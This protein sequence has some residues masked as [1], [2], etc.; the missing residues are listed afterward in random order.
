MT[1]PT[2]STRLG[3]PERTPTSRTV[4]SRSGEPLR[5]GSEAWLHAVGRAGRPLARAMPWL[6]LT[7]LNAAILAHLATNQPTASTTRPEPA[8]PDADEP[9]PAI[10]L[11]PDPFTRRRG[12]WR[13][14]VRRRSARIFGV[15]GQ[16]PRPVAV[17]LESSGRD[18]WTNG[19]QEE[20]CQ[21]T[22]DIC[23]D[24]SVPTEGSARSAYARTVEVRVKKLFRKDDTRRDSALALLKGEGDDPPTRSAVQEALGHLHDGWSGLRRSQR[25]RRNRAIGLALMFAVL[26]VGGAW[27][28]QGDVGGLTLSSSAQDQGDAS[29]EDEEPAPNAWVIAG[30]GLSGAAVS[31][32]AM[33]TRAPGLTRVPGAWL[34][35]SALKLTSGA[36]FALV[37]SW[38]IQTG[39]LVESGSPP[40][41]RLIALALLFGY[42][43]DAIT[44]RLDQKLAST[45]APATG[46]DATADA[47]P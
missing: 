46:S 44:K 6:A 25:T 28:L 42:S 24:D 5:E 38:L 4:W 7:G 21:D 29:A 35:Q 16:V 14:D 17:A 8:S 20:R 12:V 47:A 36:L 13:V 31:L 23:E 33:S 2:T 9:E 30:V 22:L 39:F 18:G 15:V 27:L 32:V 37:G 19:T 11:V 40:T 1:P 43:Q 3:T 45:K 34:A 10:D 41:G 26:T